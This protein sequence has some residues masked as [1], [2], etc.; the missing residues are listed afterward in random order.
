MEKMAEIKTKTDDV[1]HLFVIHR[2]KT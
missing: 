2:N 1:H